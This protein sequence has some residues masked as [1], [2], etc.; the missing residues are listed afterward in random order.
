MRKKKER[1]AQKNNPRPE[2]KPEEILLPIDNTD[3]ENA[4]R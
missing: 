2:E 1:E 4:R 3:D